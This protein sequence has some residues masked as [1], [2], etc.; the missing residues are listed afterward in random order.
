[1][2][3]RS[4]ND[5]INGLQNE[6]QNLI[7]ANTL[8]KEE[9]AKLQLLLEEAKTDA[10]SQAEMKI[11]ARRQ[12]DVVTAKTKQALDW[13]HD[14]TVR[15]QEYILPDSVIT[16]KQFA[17]Q[18]IELLDN[19][20]SRAM[21]KSVAQELKEEKEAMIMRAYF[22][23]SDDAWQTLTGSK[24]PEQLTTFKCNQYIR[25]LEEKEG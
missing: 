11:R 3:K 15:A 12:R 21:Q 7:Q 5:L 16:D 1:M 8:L 13:V 24:S 19:P 25:D 9:K 6:I 4:M 14:L 10:E 22:A 17:T 2:S 23:A 20:T 18:V